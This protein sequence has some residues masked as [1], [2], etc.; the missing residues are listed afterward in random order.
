MEALFCKV[1]LIKGYC[2]NVGHIIQAKKPIKT[3]LE[4]KSR[5]STSYFSTIIIF[6]YWV[7][8]IW[9]WDRSLSLHTKIK[10]T[11]IDFFSKCDQIRRKLRISSHTLKRSVTENFIFCAVFVKPL[12]HI[13][14]QKF[15]YKPNLFQKPRRTYSGRPFT[16]KLPP[17][18]SKFLYI[19]KK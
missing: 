13:R 16:N 18:F 5:N 3:H 7:I 14:P 1:N 9:A 19:Y 10:F 12:C 17:S 11:I 8:L 6:Y 15:E 2:L 4:I